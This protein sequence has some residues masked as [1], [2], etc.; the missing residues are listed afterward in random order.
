MMSFCPLWDYLWRGSLHAG[1]KFALMVSPRR[2]LG[3]CPERWI[4]YPMGC[5]LCH[6]ANLDCHLDTVDVMSK[7]LWLGRV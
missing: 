1:G 5:F 6:S 7:L 2:T 4:M 3:S